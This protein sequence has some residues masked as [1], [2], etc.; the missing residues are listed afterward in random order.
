QLEFGDDIHFKGF[1]L[2]TELAGRVRIITEEKEEPKAQ[3]KLQLVNGKYRTWNKVLDIQYGQVLFNGGPISNPALDI[4]AKRDILPASVSLNS[5]D[6]PEKVTVGVALS[7]TLKDKKLKMFSNPAMPESDIIS[8][9]V[10]G[11]P[12]AKSSREKELLFEAS[13]QLIGLIGKNSSGERLDLA[14]KLN[15]DTFGIVN[16]P[17]SL[18]G[19]SKIEE[20]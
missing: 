8:Y 12:Q 17:G 7:G 14:Q 13:Y 1:G 5:L 2:T 4:R 11:R 6:T 15:L 19:S 9:L 20:S 16:A 10:L 3:G 18:D